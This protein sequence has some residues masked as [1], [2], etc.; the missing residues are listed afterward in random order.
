MSGLAISW[1]YDLSLS[2]GNSNRLCQIATFHYLVYDWLGILTEMKFTGS[3]QALCVISWRKHLV[4]KHS[5]CVQCSTSL[6]QFL[7]GARCSLD[8]ILGLHIANQFG[9]ASAAIFAECAACIETWL[10]VASRP[11]TNYAAKACPNN[12]AAVVQ[13]SDSSRW[14][15]LS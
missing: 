10:V 8:F 5:Q 3:C 13:Q 4:N 9:H 12:S 14:E 1:W 11:S 6:V 15:Q 2:H 7:G